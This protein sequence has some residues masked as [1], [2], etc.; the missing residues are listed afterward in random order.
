MADC[1]WPG[2][3]GAAGGEW[4]PTCPQALL[5]ALWGCGDHPALPLA[6]GVPAGQAPRPLVGQDLLP[7][8]H[9]GRGRPQ[10]PLRGR[11]R[12]PPSLPARPSPTPGGAD[13]DS[14]RR[15]PTPAVLGIPVSPSG[16]RPP[17]A[18]QRPTPPGSDPPLSPLG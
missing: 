6:T 18:R 9:P 8:L 12:S 13:A 7:P 2:G 17:P 15:R 11:H 10:S 14:Q 4:T 3:S 16:H 1:A 5:P